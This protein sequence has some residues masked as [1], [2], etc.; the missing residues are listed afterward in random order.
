MSVSLS[1]LHDFP[2]NTGLYSCF[3]IDYLVEIQLRQQYSC[4]KRRH[5]TTDRYGNKNSA[6]SFSKTNN[7]LN[8]NT[9]HHTFLQSGTYSISFCI[10]RTGTSDGVT[11]MNGSNASSHFIWLIRSDTSKIVYVTN[12]QGASRLV[13]HPG[14]DGRCPRGII[15]LPYTALF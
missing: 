7:H 11:M 6:Y 9:L 8:N 4:G 1:F 3:R 5:L 2:C 15:M 14:L 10:N 12:K 13:K